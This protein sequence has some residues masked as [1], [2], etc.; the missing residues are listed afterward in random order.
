MEAMRAALAI[1]LFALAE[2]PLRTSEKLIAEG[3]YQQALDT[4]RSAPT[5]SRRHLL[6]SRA[7]DGLNR[8]ADAVR[9][10]ESA[11][12]INPRDEAAHLQLGQIFLS[13]HTP[14]GALEI[15][16]DALTS[17]P[18][19]LLL[20]LGK[21]LAL[22]DLARYDEAEP[23]LRE[24]LRRKPDFPIAF[25]ALATV[26]LHSKRFEDLQKLADNY[27]HDYPSDFRGFYFA[28]AALDGLTD[29]DEQ[30][31]PLLSRSIQLNS[32]FAAAHG[33][34]GKMKMRAAGPKAAIP[35]LEEAVRLR[36]DYS[37]AV[38]QLAQAYQR[39]GR[40]S[41]AARV[42][43]TLR[44]LKERERIPPPSLLYHRGPR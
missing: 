38:L 22:K 17:I 32:N 39:G 33:L 14:A 7:H 10:A 6:A 4:L 16:T 40:E 44:E 25:D 11:L 24:C 29:F 30:M 28:A 43:Q 15:F 36:P 13:H 9:E 23:E 19:S 34:L 1:L 42:F 20:R 31:A 3:R 21:G 2:D 35:H 5:G 8:P 12:A 18:D 41:D 26:L 27:R 37:P